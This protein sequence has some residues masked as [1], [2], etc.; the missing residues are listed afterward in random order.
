[1]MITAES[2]ANGLIGGRK[3]GN[4]YIACCPCHDDKSP[5]LGIKDGRTQILLN[6]WAGCRTIDII[7]ALKDMGLWE[8]SQKA[9]KKG[10]HLSSEDLLELY[11]FWFIAKGDEEIWGLSKA[12][13]IRVRNARCALDYFCFGPKEAQETVRKLTEQKGSMRV[14][15]KSPSRLHERVGEV[16]GLLR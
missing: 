15:G 8:K 13:E 16:V 2:I 12:E 4:G 3:S 7:N 14:E 11:M 9:V 1:M 6:C 5:T 10:P